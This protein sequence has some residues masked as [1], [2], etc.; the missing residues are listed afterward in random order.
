MKEGEGEDG[1]EGRASNPWEPWE[2]LARSWRWKKRIERGQEVVK[3]RG[4]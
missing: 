1:G 4:E 2:L 3:N